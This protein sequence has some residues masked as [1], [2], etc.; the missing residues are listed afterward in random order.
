MAHDKVGPR[1]MQLR[2]LAQI[3]RAGKNERAAAREATIAGLKEA[4]A[5]TSEAMVKP[6]AKVKAKKKKVRA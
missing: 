3:T 5:K 1:E 4:M 6:K 2:Q